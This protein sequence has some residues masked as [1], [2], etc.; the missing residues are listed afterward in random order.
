MVAYSLPTYDLPFD[1]NFPLLLTKLY[2]KVTMAKL[3]C[4]IRPSQFA[5]ARGFPVLRIYCAMIYVPL[6]YKEIGE[7]K[8]IEHVK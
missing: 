8:Y 7:N 5:T 2:W 1:G 4:K 6:F 3:V